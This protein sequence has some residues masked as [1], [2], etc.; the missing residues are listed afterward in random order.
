VHLNQQQAALTE[1]VMAVLAIVLSAVIATIRAKG[2]IPK[3]T[4]STSDKKQRPT[5]ATINWRLAATNNN[6][7]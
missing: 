7:N 1:A 5:K 4:Q 6:S 2:I 3:R